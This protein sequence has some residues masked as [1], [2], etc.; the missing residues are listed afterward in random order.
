M[1][2][3]GRVDPV[4][5]GMTQLDSYLAR[6]GLDFGWLVIFDR[7]SNAPTLEERL[8]STI[9]TSPGGRSITLIRA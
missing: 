6:L 9:R 1:G 7:R 8:S 4:T 5:Q 3:L 2:N